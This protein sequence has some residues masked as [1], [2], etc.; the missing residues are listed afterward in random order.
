MMQTV[1]ALKPIK[2]GRQ[3]ETGLRKIIIDCTAWTQ[4]YDGIGIIFVAVRPGETEQ[5][6]PSGVTISSGILTWVPD[7]YDTANAGH[8][9]VMIQ[10]VSSDGGILK[11]AKA[12][13][14]IEDAFGVDCE[15][16]TTGPAATIEVSDAMPVSPSKLLISFE[17]SQEGSGDAS[18]EN[19]RAI[20]P[21]SLINL[22]HTAG[23]AENVYILEWA[24]KSGDV[25]AGTLDVMN[26]KLTV[27]HK[28][29]AI[30][31][32]TVDVGTF[33]EGP[34]GNR[35]GFEV[36]KSFSISE[37]MVSGFLCNIARPASSANSGTASNWVSYTCALYRGGS[38]AQRRFYFRYV[39]PTSV[40]TAADALEY[41]VS[42]GC[43]ITYPLIEPIVYQIDPASIKLERG[44][45][46]LTTDV[47]EI[48]LH[49]LREVS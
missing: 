32:D 33:G 16:G 7:E 49:Y 18:P 31:A 46:T 25:C 4:A 41:L 36:T 14:C 37:S 28:K 15:I 17:Q 9:L 20:T 44:T 38:E 29:L 13:F 6:M 40:T 48:T 43:E 24:T 30:N 1:N 39:F 10:G 23:G 42:N 5:Y 26:G 12:E 11:S 21:T 22:T 19:P 47:G 45:N 34:N 3:G 35:C 8:G 2:A 27:T